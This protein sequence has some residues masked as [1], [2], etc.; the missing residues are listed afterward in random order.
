MDLNEWF[1][2]GLTVNAYI[3]SMKVNQEEMLQI[4]KSYSLID[5]NKAK[6]L[7]NYNLRALILTADW[8]GDAMVNLP[9]L[10]VNLLISWIKVLS[11]IF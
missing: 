9:I 8:C 3:S 6:Q 10:N 4:S 7:R 5:V 11:L 1:E 2:K